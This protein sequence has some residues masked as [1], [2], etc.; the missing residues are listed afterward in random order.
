MRLNQRV[1]VVTG[2]ARGIGE[3]IAQCLAH[4]GARVAVLD[5]DGDEAVRTAE[6][7][8]AQHLGLGADV[9]NE[10]AAATALEQVVARY[11][12]VDFLINNAGGG[13][14]KAA[15]A[16]GP[17]F[18]RVMQ[19]GWDEQMVLNLRTN[20]AATKAAIPYLKAQDQGVIVNI[21][22]VAALVPSVAMPG[23]AA[24]KAAVISL[25]RTLAVELAADDIRVNAICP[26]LLYTRAWRLLASNI[27]K[28]SPRLADKT[29]YDVF[30]NIVRAQTPL[31]R[32]QTPED[33]GKLTGF[34]CSDEA[35]NITGQVIALDG[36]STLRGGG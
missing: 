16:S 35:R 4:D 15:T 24:A 17:P 13:N 25:T 36:G 1:A 33:V 14:R 3:G 19:E 20:F 21:A 23:Y 12:Q 26:G 10:K 6:K 9:S 30:L 22:S 27:Q 32:E 31:G 34:L 28:S 29:P 5:L 2:G 11:G 18:T 8:G 7:L